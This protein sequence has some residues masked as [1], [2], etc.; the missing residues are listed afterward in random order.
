MKL[1]ILI[2]ASLLSF[3]YIPALAESTTGTAV[4][5]ELGQ[6]KKDFKV[7]GKAGVRRFADKIGWLG[8]Q[9][10][11]LYD[12][13]NEELMAIYHQ[14]GRVS[15]EYASWLVKVL[16]ASGLQKYAATMDKI[17]ASG[18]HKK[19]KKHT[20]IARKRLE[21]TSI[22]NPIISKGTETAGTQDELTETRVTNMLTSEIPELVR[23]GAKIVLNGH[24]SEALLD[25]IDQTLR[26]TYT[27][28]P[29]NLNERDAINWLIKT[30]GSSGISRYRATLE[31]VAVDAPDAKNRKYARK[32]LDYL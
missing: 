7:Y 19:L 28:R 11:T 30:L 20:T 17:I 6:L 22:W 5:T 21:L 24:R 14:A 16:A 32:Y 8:I 2:L 31:A 12:P 9:D 13:I 27:D 29:K 26:D 3:I 18:A 1:S 15:V 4:E 23:V 10:E 25:L